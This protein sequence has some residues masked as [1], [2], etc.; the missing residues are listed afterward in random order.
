M[1]FSTLASLAAVSAVGLAADESEVNF[2]TALVSDY[3]D[4]KKEYVDFI[5]TAT[6]VPAGLTS[7][8]V[9]VATYTDDSYT[10]LLDNSAINV[11]SLMSFA[12]ELPWYTRLEAEVEAGEDG[13]AASAASGS[14]GSSATSTLTKSSSSSSLAGAA[15]FFAP[16]GALLGTLA[17][18][19]M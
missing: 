9:A 4:N 5:R 19:L 16:A 12:T 17:L 1:K 2:L 18:V 14:S 15:T 3:N 11:E 7:L 6:D 10:T 13:S 8:A